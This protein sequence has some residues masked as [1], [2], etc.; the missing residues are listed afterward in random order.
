MDFRCSIWKHIYR[1]PATYITEGAPKVRWIHGIP[2][3]NW[4][5]DSLQGG[6]RTATP[7]FQCPPLRINPAFRI[8]KSSNFT[9]KRR[10]YFEILIYRLLERRSPDLNHEHAVKRQQR[11]IRVIAGL[12]RI[13]A[14]RRK[15]W[16]KSRSS[17]GQFNWH[18]FGPENWPEM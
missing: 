7:T 10:G 11:G 5:W 8:V 4:K 16:T 14:L 12:Q 9:S 15:R 1:P 13:C 3:S 18:K 17:G 2:Y 6:G